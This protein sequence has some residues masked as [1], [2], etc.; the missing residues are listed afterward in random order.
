MERARTI[1]PLSTPVIFT[2]AKKLLRWLPL[3]SIVFFAIQVRQPMIDRLGYR[4]DTFYYQDWTTQAIRGGLFSLYK[5]TDLVE[6]DHPPVGPSILTLSVQLMVARGGTLDVKVDQNP[7]Y[8]HALKLPPVIFD[9]LLIIAGYAIVQH[10]YGVGLATI[11]GA[12]LGFTPAFIADSA[13]WGQTDVIFALFLVLTVYALHRRW[14]TLA[15]VLFAV[16]MLTKFQG[17][18]L[19]PLLIVLTWRRSTRRIFFRGVLLF[20]AIMFLVLLPF[21]IVSGAPE[22]LR[23]YTE[24][25]IKYPFVTLK[26]FNFWYW[27]LSSSRNMTADWFQMPPDT[28][29]NY[30]Q[31]DGVYWGPITARSVGFALFGLIALLIAVRAWLNPDRDP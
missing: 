6:V 1:T 24:G 9:I 13:W 7:D 8:L 28:A 15:W 26:A 23:P 12:A 22:T 19:F 4:Y 18:A 5:N 27:A 3:A 16:T 20:A 25:A 17:I 29:V 11:V 21:M 14:T 10:E 31:A 2:W 30:G